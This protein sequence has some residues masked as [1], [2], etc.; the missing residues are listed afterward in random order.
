MTSRAMAPAQEWASVRPKKYA[1]P[2]ARPDS[3]TA[4]ATACRP[5]IRPRTSR[6]KME[7][8]REGAEELLTARGCACAQHAGTAEYRGARRHD[9]NRRNLC[10][11]RRRGAQRAPAPSAAAG[12]GSAPLVERAVCHTAAGAQE[13]GNSSRASQTR[14]ASLRSAGTQSARLSPRPPFHEHSALA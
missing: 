12:Q 11:L 8:V 5:Q 4:G 2:R 13:A 6:G 7:A 14:T 9:G 3:P 1:P 10:S